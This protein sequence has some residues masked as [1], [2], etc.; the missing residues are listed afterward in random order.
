MKLFANAEY[1]NDLK[2]AKSIRSDIRSLAK[3][4]NKNGNLRSLA[5]KFIK[6]EPSLVDDIVA[7]N[8]MAAK[9][10]EAIKGSTIKNIN[11]NIA[12][13]VKISEAID[14]INKA[15]KNQDEIIKKEKEADLEDVMSIDGSDLTLSQIKSLLQSDKEIPKDKEKII[16]DKIK[17]PFDLYSSIIKETLSTGKDVFTGEEVKVKKSAKKLVKE[18]MDMDLNVLD[19]KESLDVVDSLINFLA[20]QSTA[21]MQSVISNYNGLVNVKKLVNKKIVSRPIRKFGSPSLGRVL[22]E[23]VTPLPIVVERM[24]P[25]FYRSGE[26]SDAMGLTELINQST[27]AEKQSKNIINN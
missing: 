21:K 15:I 19:I 2:N 16:R 17:K 20:N 11:V 18:F 27:N 26:V 9:I 14:F 4:D 23:Q 12:E 1:A 5:T 6:I 8:K 13:T 3:D 7:Y 25:G 10:K 24:F 22:A